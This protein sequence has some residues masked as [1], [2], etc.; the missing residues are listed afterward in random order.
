MRVKEERERPSFDDMV[1][2]LADIQRR[3]LLIALLDHNPQDD[4][5]VVIADSEDESDAIERL[6]KM[7][8]VH[9]PKLVEYGFI[10][11][12]E[13]THEV[14]KGPNFDEIRPLLELLNDHEDEL[15]DDWL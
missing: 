5:P 15:P 2:A 11:W 13:E 8:H 7:D 6:V 9:L 1:D 10:E 14:S 4:S 12:N 3:K